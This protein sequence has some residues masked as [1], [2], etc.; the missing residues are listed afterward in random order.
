MLAGAADAVASCGLA[1]GLAGDS[2]TFFNAMDG[3]AAFDDRGC[4]LDDSGY[5]A[6]GLCLQ[7]RDALLQFLHLVEK[8]TFPIGQRSLGRVRLRRG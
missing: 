8:H 6:I 5:F 1:V 2:V 3:S 4:A 7:F